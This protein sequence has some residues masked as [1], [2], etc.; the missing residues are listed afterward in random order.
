VI[1][2]TQWLITTS[3]GLNKALQDSNWIMVTVFLKVLEKQVWKLPLIPHLPL[4]A[5]IKIFEA[6]FS[7]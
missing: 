7:D 1:G 2:T 4:Q 5:M 3:R 6:L